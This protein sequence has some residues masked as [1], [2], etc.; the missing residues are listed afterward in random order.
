MK[1]AI[2]PLYNENKLFNNWFFDHKLYGSI[3]KIN[4][5]NDTIT[6][7]LLDKREDKDDFVIVSFS[8]FSIFDFLFNW[9]LLNIWRILKKYKNKKILVIS[10]PKVVDPIS[11]N[12]IF[13]K[14]FDYVLTFDELMVDNKKYFKYTPAMLLSNKVNHVPSYDE[15]K[16]LTL[17][18]WNKWGYW[19]NELYSRREKAIRYYEKYLPSDFDL[20]G[21]WR[22]KPNVKQRIFWYK[23]YPSY[24]WTIDDKYLTLSKYKF[25]ICFENQRNVSW[26]ISE[27]IFDSLLS[28]SIPIYRWADDIDKYVPRDCFIDFRD[29]MDFDKLT[30]YLNNM[31]SKTYN[32]YIY[33]IDNFVFDKRL[34]NDGWCESLLQTIKKCLNV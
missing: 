31:D 10:E 11:Y 27:K 29:F 18:N 1:L 6:I 21:I 9:R 28:K 12:K 13:H 26:Y 25:N 8:V 14:F 22:D 24:K 20:Y 32:Q 19:K 16:F 2:I 3:R 34:Y 17:I 33:N 23:K 5:F 30:A 7:D 4:W 15:K